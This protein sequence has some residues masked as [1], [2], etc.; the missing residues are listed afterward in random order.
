MIR[1]HHTTWFQIP[2]RGGWNVYTTN[3]PQEPQ[4]HFDTQ[5]EAI[6]YAVN[7]SQREG[8]DMVIEEYPAQARW[9]V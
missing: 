7:M 5:E 6:A 3:K 8:V 2:V 4:V 1:R 9:E